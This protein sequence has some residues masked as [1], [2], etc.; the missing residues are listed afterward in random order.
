MDDEQLFEARACP[1]CAEPH[2]Q[3]RIAPKEALCPS[4]SDVEL[5]SAKWRPIQMHMQMSTEGEATQ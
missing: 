1:L 5:S 4:C 2:A 3:L